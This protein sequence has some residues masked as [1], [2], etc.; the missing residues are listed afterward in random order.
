MARLLERDCVSRN[1][2]STRRAGTEARQQLVLYSRLN[3][4]LTMLAVEQRF[5]PMRDR[6]LADRII[7]AARQVGIPD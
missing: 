5:S 3:P 1:P 7:S 2:L 4:Q 6:A